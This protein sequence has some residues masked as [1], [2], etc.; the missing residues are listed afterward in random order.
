MVLKTIINSLIKLDKQLNKP[1][2]YKS[3]DEKYRKH[4]YNSNS[5]TYN[6]RKISAIRNAAA[7]EKEIERLQDKSYKEE[8]DRDVERMVHE[9]HKRERW[10]KENPKR[11]LEGYDGYERRM[12]LNLMKAKY[13]KPKYNWKKH[14]KRN[15]NYKISRYY[16]AY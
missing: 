14:V 3:W 7:R 6:G 16:S 4:N 13:K 15:Q 1:K 10:M 2:K 9:E 5:S 8:M 12:V 11:T